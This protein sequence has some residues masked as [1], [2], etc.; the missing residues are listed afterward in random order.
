MQ[1]EKSV[2]LDKLLEDVE[3]SFAN[4]IEEIVQFIKKILVIIHSIID[5]A[6]DTLTY[7][8]EKNILYIQCP[9]LACL[10]ALSVHL[11]LQG[12]HK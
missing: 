11:Y 2:S 9:F 4:L 3:E 6:F 7:V 10:V 5:G 12:I 8:D 1:E